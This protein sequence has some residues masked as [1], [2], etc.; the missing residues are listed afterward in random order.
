MT[1]PQQNPRRPKLQPN[2]IAARVFSGNVRIFTLLLA[3]GVDGL[4]A[5]EHATPRL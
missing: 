3:G 2:R 4:A 1:I 5:I